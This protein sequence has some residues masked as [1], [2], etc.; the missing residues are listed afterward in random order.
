MHNVGSNS[1]RVLIIIIQKVCKALSRNYAFWTA[2][3]TFR[4]YKYNLDINYQN[5][6]NVKRREIKWI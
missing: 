6:R 3:C 5:F 4:K 1:L 2:H